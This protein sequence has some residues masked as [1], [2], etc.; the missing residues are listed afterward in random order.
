[1]SLVSIEKTE[2]YAQ[3]AVDAAIARHFETLGVERDLRPG[4]RV[5]IKPNL[6]RAMKPENTGTTHPSVL[7]AAAKWLR[8]HGIDDITIADS[9]GGPHIAANLRTVYAVSGLKALEGTAKLNF[10]LGWHEVRCPEGY[11]S[12]S[13][14]IIDPLA[15]ADYI[16]NIAKLKTHSMT[17]L[18]AGIKNMFGAVPGL[19]KPELHYK[20]PEPRD[21]A[22]MILEVAGTVKPDLTVIDAVECMEGNGPTSGETR[23]LGV[24]LASRD[25]YA[26]DYVAARLIGIEP[27][28]VDMLSL[29]VEKGLLDAGAITLTGSAAEMQ[30]VSFTLPDSKK[31]DFIDFLPKFIRKP[32]SKI[33]GAVLRPVPVLEREKCVGCGKCAESCPPKLIEIKDGRA[34]FPDKGCI[35]CFCCQEMCPAH[36]IKV[37]CRFKAKLKIRT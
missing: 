15:Q 8:A 17:T 3:D 29:A 6:V 18:S 19:Q 7:L 37:E 16:I 30:P 22:N 13:F 28:S 4:M 33:A 31:P 23:Y 12:G 25:I 9:P 20:Y 11:K 21:F 32:V 5:V 34:R 36:A 14:N 10:D 27:S 1:M 35:S 26:Q 2:S 24:T